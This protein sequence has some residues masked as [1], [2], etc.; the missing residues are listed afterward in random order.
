MNW[1]WS[2]AEDGALSYL[3]YAT[4]VLY[5]R[6]LRR[7]MDFDNGIVGVSRR[8]SELMFAEWM[9]VHRS[10]GSTAKRTRPT[11]SEVRIMI[12]QLERNGLVERV[13]NGQGGVWPLVFRLPLARTGL[14]R[15]NEEQPRNSQKITLCTTTLSRADEKIIKQIFPPDLPSVS[16]GL[17]AVDKAEKSGEKIPMNNQKK[18]DQNAEEQPTSG[19]SSLSLNNNIITRARGNR[20]NIPDDWLPKV[21]I[22]K[23]LVIYFQLPPFF[24][25][26]KAIE[27]RILWREQNVIALDWDAYFYGACQNKINERDGE[28]LTAQQFFTKRG[29]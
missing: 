12:R 19:K 16:A 6:I 1:S 10:R 27:F 3:P 28:F 26:L 18:N 11:R 21:S 4:Q 22:A 20:S 9:E 24:I 2:G 25:Q 5:L 29:G 13:S 23:K 17:K 8:L 15:P 7:Y 14:V